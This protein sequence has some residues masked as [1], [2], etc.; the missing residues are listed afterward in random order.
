MD[1]SSAP[2][3]SLPPASGGWPVPGG[4]SGGAMAPGAGGGAVRLDRRR[5]YVLPTGLGLI[6]A[7]SLLVMLLGS[8]NYDTSLGYLLTFLLAGVALVSMLHAWRNLYGLVVRV[9]SP[10]PVHA[11]ESLV[12]PVT[13]E[14]G[15]DHRA[16]PGATAPARP[17]LVLSTEPGLPR[18]SGRHRAGTRLRAWRRFPGRGG[19]GSHRRGWEPGGSPP[20]GEGAGKPPGPAPEEGILHIALEG[21]RIH[22]YGLRVRAHARG[23][24]PLPPV[25]LATRHPLGLFRAWSRIEPAGEAIVWPAPKGRP[26]LP[27]AR[28][29]EDQG[30]GTTSREGMDDLQGFREYVPGDSPRAIHW[31][32]VARGARQVPVKVFAGERG[33]EL[34]LTWEAAGPGEVESRLGQLALWIS[35]LADTD[36]RFGVELPGSGLPPGR[37]E[38]HRLRA[39]ELLARHPPGSER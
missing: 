30:E 38:G 7:S 2:G 29:V 13:L 36:I 28:P 20:S 34:V 32:G 16:L 27:P 39:L 6:W 15:I 4:R 1:A 9:G 23:V 11:G 33:A 37:G 10:P 24:W 17:G 3:S 12:I 35:A 5:I 31:K 21:G 26:G 8:I 25:V 22:R 14:D 19:D 18:R